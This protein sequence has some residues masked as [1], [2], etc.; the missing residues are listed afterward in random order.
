M[1]RSITLPVA[2]LTLTLSGAAPAHAVV[3]PTLDRAFGTNE[4]GANIIAQ[5]QTEAGNPLVAGTVVHFI[6]NSL[7]DV[8]NPKTG[9]T[10]QFEHWTGVLITPEWV[11][12]CA[13]ALQGTD[14]R[15]AGVNPADKSACIPPGHWNVTNRGTIWRWFDS[16]CRSR[17]W[18]HFRGS[19]RPVSPALPEWSSQD[20]VNK[21]RAPMAAT[22]CLE[23]RLPSE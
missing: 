1:K 17:V 2:L 20:T 12:T 10:N 18:P 22:A 5:M 7:V 8:V 9:R 23:G 19:R 15:G 21:A 14:G 11:L 16:R 13:H 6:N 3:T 4:A